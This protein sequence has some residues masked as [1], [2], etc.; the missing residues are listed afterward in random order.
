MPR[1]YDPG[2]WILEGTV[3]TQG[4]SIGSNLNDMLRHLALE[5]E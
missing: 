5:P 3:T 1:K 2:L 4:V